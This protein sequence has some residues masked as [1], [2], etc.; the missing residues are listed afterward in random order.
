V[1]ELG[2]AASSWYPA[3][4]EKELVAAAVVAEEEMRPSCLYFL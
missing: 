2:V 4:V 3:A 1:V